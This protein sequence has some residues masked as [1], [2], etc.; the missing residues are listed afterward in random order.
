M[1]LHLYP[2]VLFWQSPR[3]NNIIYNI[4]KHKKYKVNDTVIKM[5]ELS[6][7]SKSIE[8]ILNLFESTLYDEVKCSLEF[9]IQE[10][11]LTEND[12][13]IVK[14]KQFKEVETFYLSLTK[15][16][17]LKCHFC[18]K[19]TS[20]GEKKEMD[21]KEWMNIID[22]IDSFTSTDKRTL[23]LSGGEPLI[24]SY[25]HDLYVYIYQKG[26]KVHIFSNATTI[27]TK[28][29]ELFKEYPPNTLLISIDGSVAHIHDK[30][31]GVEGAFEKLI[32]NTKRIIAESI[33]TQ[34]I[35]QTVIDSNNI[36]DME[37]IAQLALEQ[38]VKSIRFSFITSIGGGI[39][40]E[41]SLSE[42]LM[43]VFYEKVAKLIK[44]YKGKLKI[45]QPINNMEIVPNNP[46]II[47]CGIGNIL[48]IDEQGFLTPCYGM[49]DD[50][51]RI[52]KADN[53]QMLKDK[54]I[55]PFFG[56]SIETYRAC[57]SCGIRYFC[58]GGCKAEI[59]ENKKSIHECMKNKKR[60]MINYLSKI[61]DC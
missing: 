33:K 45:N 55:S 4:N 47:S 27:D 21:L 48:H 28:V 56:Y 10:N 16:C 15:Q 11:I 51:H 14:N 31:R 8:D 19:K 34:I 20:T 52:D 36:M 41:N 39:D 29:I 18:L 43:V 7:G 59:L 53:L 38:G 25:F 60:A 54:E 32:Q 26:F 58:N 40:N 5:L 6:D 12:R 50:D 2:N 30:Q 1:S 61:I 35:W 13:V 46:Q 22:H 57:A 37:K 3:G 23:Y 17:N 9:L 42:E 49:N 24:Y 44:D